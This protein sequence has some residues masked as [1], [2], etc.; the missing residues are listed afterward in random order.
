MQ[1]TGTIL[2]DYKLIDEDGNIQVNS[3]SVDVLGWADVFVESLEVN[4]KKE[5]GKKQDISIVLTN[6]NEIY[7]SK[8]YNGHPAQGK[9]NLIANDEVIHSSDYN[10]QPRGSV[11]TTFH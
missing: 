2:L 7:M 5:K 10:I 1:Y 8:W 9:L 11:E 6:Y 4:G 3:T